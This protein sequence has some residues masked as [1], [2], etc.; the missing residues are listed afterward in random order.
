MQICIGLA[1]L[2][3]LILWL[4]HTECTMENLNTAT[5]PAMWELDPGEDHCPAREPIGS[6]LELLE[7]AHH[8]SQSMLAQVAAA[9]DLTAPA[10]DLAMQL[11]QQITD[12]LATAKA[13]QAA[14]A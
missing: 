11:Q 3:V 4:I 7:D 1:Q 8:D 2:R 9:P 14:A 10:R 12:A 5:L 6:L 13:L